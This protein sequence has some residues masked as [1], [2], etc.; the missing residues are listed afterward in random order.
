MSDQ[1]LKRLIRDLP[2]VNASPD[3]T[4]RVM[5]RLER[6][7]S[8]ASR[9]RLR[10][11]WAATA[12]AALIGLAVL[13][14]FRLAE[15]RRIALAT[16]QLASLKAEREQLARELASIAQTPEELAAPAP[17]YLGSNPD[18]DVVL[19]LSPRRVV[20]GTQPAAFRP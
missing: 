13:G 4:R 20:H 10:I 16:A 17:V 6:N 15:E 2:P 8:S 12:A 1:H 3:F 19:D 5:E 14:G 7:P 9:H 11:A 18:M